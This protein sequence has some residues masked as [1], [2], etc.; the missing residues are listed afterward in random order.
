MGQVSPGAS[1][2][3]GFSIQAPRLQGIPG[4]RHLHCNGEADRPDI[5]R[6]LP[7]ADV[8][9]CIPVEDREEEKR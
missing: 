6:A 9:G 1:A 2:S 4:S 8:Q 5:V 7:A 3:S